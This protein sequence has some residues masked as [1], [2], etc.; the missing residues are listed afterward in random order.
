MSKAIKTEIKSLKETIGVVSLKNS[1]GRSLRNVP[2]TLLKHCECGAKA[3]HLGVHLG[4]FLLLE[5]QD[6]SCSKEWFVCLN[7]PA[8]RA[9]MTTLK[10]VK[11]HIA[12]ERKKEKEAQKKQ[13]SSHLAR[14]QFING[15]SWSPPTLSRLDR[16][17]APVVAGAPLAAE[18][19]GFPLL[20]NDCEDSAS[21]HH[22]QQE[23]RLPNETNTLGYD[24][25]PIFLTSTAA[26]DVEWFDVRDG[27][28]L[29]F[30][31]E[32]SRHFF[33][34]SFLCNGNG[35]GIDYL[36]KRSILGRFI[37][38]N[39][40]E[41]MVL[42]PG[43]SDL[44]MRIARLAFAL[45]GG[46]RDLFAEILAGC[47]QVGCE[48]GYAC[49]QDIELERNKKKGQGHNKDFVLPPFHSSLVKRPA[50]LWSIR[51]P[52]TGN[53]LRRQIIEGSNSI[54]ANLPIPTIHDDI[55]GHSYI[56]VVDC[57]R[58]LLAHPA[59]QNI[60]ILSEN[61]ADGTS[62]VVGHCSD[63]KRAR[64]LLIAATS[65]DGPG[66]SIKI[67]IFLWS[68]DW[69]PN[70]LSKAGRGSIWMLTMTVG[71]IL[72]NGHC[73]NH[74]YP[75]AVGKK[76]DDHSPV[77][78]RIEEDCQRMRT[79]NTSPFF[80]GVTKKRVRVIC[81]VFACLH[82][83]PEKREFNSMRGGTSHHTGRFGVSANH[84]LL[85][86][87]L[88]A[89]ERCLKTMKE[90]VS[91]EEWTLPLPVCNEC[92][93]W[94][95]LNDPNQLGLY[96][97]PDN[98]P[99]IPSDAAEDHFYKCSNQCR[100]VE[101]NGEQLLKPF[102]ITYET[103]RSGIAFAHAAFVDHDWN[104]QNCA[105]YLMVEG[106]D[107]KTIQQFADHAV[108]SLCL[109]VAKADP[110]KHI[111]ILNDAAIN[112]TKYEQLPTP[113]AWRRPN[114]S[115]K[116]H[117][118]VIMHLLFLGGVKTTMLRI[119][120]W[121]ATQK[122]NTSFIK[123]TAPYLVS[124]VAKTIDW[125]EIMPYSGQGFGG[126]VSS[127]Y[128]GFAR[129]MPWF[130]QN[131]GEAFKTTD[132]IPPEGLSQKKWLAAHNRYWLESRGLDAT[133][134]ATD[135][136]Q[137]VADYLAEDNP[138]EPLP[139]PDLSTSHVE[140]V[141]VCLN[142]LL[143]CIM[144]PV[145]TPNLIGKTKYLVRIFLSFY[146]CLAQEV[147]KYKPTSESKKTP[148]VLSSFNFICFMNLPAMMERFGPLRDMWEGGPKGEGFLRFTKQHIIHGLRQQSWHYHL[149]KSLLRFKVLHT[150]SP[151]EN[152]TVPAIDS[153]DALSHRSGHFHKYDSQFTLLRLISETHRN[154]K[155]PISVLLLQRN[156]NLQE[157]QHGVTLMAVVGDYC[158]V[159]EIVLAEN[160]DDPIKTFGL[161]YYRVDVS[162][163]RCVPWDTVA[164]SVTKLGYALLLPLMDGRNNDDTRR[165]AIVSS[166]WK[167]LSP[168][169]AMADLLD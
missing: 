122:K 19:E 10:Q 3:T 115:I 109:K 49:A 90:R 94:D 16:D 113:V 84:V 150:L 43:H 161:F 12:N 82:D 6:D 169:T 1:N 130:Y 28:D 48:D 55:G 160:H 155:E 142:E 159:I 77:I 87:K 17:F 30:T 85:Y 42:P 153:S 4:H 73:I 111:G 118:D 7:C 154:K 112:P 15:C 41:R 114:T 93:N 11:K 29:G 96:P 110:N 56:S 145:V 129:I 78:A 123:T 58:D 80:V 23:D 89:C 33:H 69:E 13:T 148:P 47:H 143:G 79:G 67:Y 125:A 134:K 27:H 106:I 62:E 104:Q 25:A 91:E 32:T 86:P 2:E 22:P 65:Y 81:D 147:R 40:M 57:I 92:L 124:M 162:E 35:G 71:T 53:D 75:I 46:E 144:S 64:E 128:L 66:R 157:V 74:T 44:Q 137:R 97:P 72:D 105:A 26:N 59:V 37:P 101:K 61:L 39:D 132:N 18:G 45:T 119:Q 60:A 126:W 63:S 141:V 103:L 167:H 76:G 136:R 140:D 146:D 100:I 50:H 21:H 99:L 120:K 9:R 70:R 31:S 152:K 5:C 127:N 98:Y 83:Q 36:V 164:P 149:L 163:E 108:N 165:F 8:Q 38:M 24:D 68:D 135:L 166:N 102:Q 156:N 14:Q 52:Q 88:K 116:E 139:E 138:P 117:P 54:V 151:Q 107:E 158:S 20:N 95:V 133:G 168:K 131:I 121:L 34:S 51:I